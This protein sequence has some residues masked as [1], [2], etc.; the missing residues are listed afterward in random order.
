MTAR[1]PSLQLAPDE[2]LEIHPANAGAAG[3]CD[4]DRVEVASRRGAI[5][6]RA[7]LSE[8]ARP[9]RPSSPSTSPRSPPTA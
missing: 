7:R 8:R 4:G 2:R 3:V 6:L 9:A 1:T 5:A